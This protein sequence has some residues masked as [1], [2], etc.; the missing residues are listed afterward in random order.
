[1]EKRPWSQKREKVTEPP[2]VSGGAGIRFGCGV[3]FGAFW[4]GVLFLGLTGR[5]GLQLSGGQGMVAWIFLAVLFGF[6]SLIF[7]KRFWDN[8]TGD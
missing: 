2:D 4:G 8:F 1:M 6:L 7:G 3:L 5:R